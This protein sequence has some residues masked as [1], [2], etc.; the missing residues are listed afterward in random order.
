M[1]F[2]KGNISGTIE[3]EDKESRNSFT[4]EVK[5]LPQ[6]REREV[7]SPKILDS[8]EIKTSV[9]FFAHSGS[10]LP[11]KPALLQETELSTDRWHGYVVKVEEESLVIDI[12]NDM[13]PQNRLKLR[14]KKSIVE[15]DVRNL[16]ELT[17]VIV[18]CK[19]VRTYQDN[20]KNKVSVRLRE[21]AVM[22]E[23]VLEKDLEAKM[24]RFSYMFTED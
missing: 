16:N 17:S 9:C 21:P 15:G 13:E 5:P 11:D 7:G 18:Y 24:T 23:T 14:V 19:R 4:V 1:N 12:R 8:F 6:P 2:Y 10:V 20:I 22:T 3:P